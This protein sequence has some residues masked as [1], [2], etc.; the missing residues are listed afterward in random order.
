MFLPLLS[1]EI[2]STTSDE[3][4]IDPSTIASGERC[5]IPSFTSWNAPPFFSFSSTNFTAEEPISRPTTFLL[6]EKNTAHPVHHTTHFSLAPDVESRSKFQRLKVSVNST[7]FRFIRRLRQ[8]GLFWGAG[9][10]R[11][12]SPATI[13]SLSRY[14]RSQSMAKMCEVCGKAPVFG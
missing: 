7:A 3:S 6:F 12:G 5:S 9:L 10:R 1:R 14:L 4:M 13:P 11:T 2:V 8:V